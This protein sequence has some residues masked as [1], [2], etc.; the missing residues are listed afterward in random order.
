LP[1]ALKTGLF[2][3]KKKTGKNAGT[4]KNLLPSANFTF[5]LFRRAGNEGGIFRTSSAGRNSTTEPQHVKIPKLVAVS[6][7][8]LFSGA[9]RQMR[10]R[11][12]MISALRNVDI[13]K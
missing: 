5:T 10:I 9:A 13:L 8:L 11:M 12:V 1:E 7:F 4:Q 6:G 3:D 2:L